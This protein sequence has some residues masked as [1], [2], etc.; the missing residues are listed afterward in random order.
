M[1]YGRCQL[2]MKSLHFVI[3]NF[4]RDIHMCLKQK[5]FYF[6]VSKKA[7]NSETIFKILQFQ[8]ENKHCVN[9]IH[10]FSLKIFKKQSNVFK[11]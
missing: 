1:I 8:L 9:G 6:S 7:Y 3:D 11:K 5:S 4:K 10:M 2:S